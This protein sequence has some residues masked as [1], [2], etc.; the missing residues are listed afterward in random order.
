M[1]PSFFGNNEK[2]VQYVQK[3]LDSSKKRGKLNKIS[4]KKLIYLRKLDKLNI[5]QMFTKIEN[6]NISEKFCMYPK[7]AG[8]MQKQIYITK[9]CYI[10]PRMVRYV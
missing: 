4:R 10:Y 7:R 5:L 3:K 2:N 6:L 8:Y 9:I 1:Y